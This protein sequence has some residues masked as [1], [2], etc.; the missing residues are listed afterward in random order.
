MEKQTLT[1]HTF[2]LLKA[3]CLSGLFLLSS[4]GLNAQD[5]STSNL[6][7][8][9][10]SQ[11]SYTTCE[12]SSNGVLEAIGFNGSPG[13]SYVWSDGQTTAIAS[14]LDVGDYSV[15]VTDDAGCTAT[16]SGAIS[17]HPEGVWIMTSFTAACSGS[18]SGTA[19]VSAMLGTEPYSYLWSDG[20]TSDDAVGLAS[21][22]YGVTVTDALGCSAE[23]TVTIPNASGLSLFTTSS[24]ETCGGSNDATATVVASG[25]VAPYTYLWD[26]GQTT[27]IATGLS[28]GTIGVTVTDA[29]GCQ[30]T[31]TQ[32]V[33]LSP[34]GIWIM[35]SSTP[36]VCGESNGTAH[37]SVM[38]G[39]PPYTFLWNDPAMQ[40]TAD[41]VGLAAGVY[42]VVVTDSNG[43]E[44]TEMVT[45]DGSNAPNPGSISTNDPVEFC[46]TDGNSHIINVTTTGAD[47][48]AQFAYVLT[49]DALNILNISTTPSFDLTGAPAG[50]CLI[51]RVA[52]DGSL[53]GAS[54]GASATGLGGCFA[55]S[56]P[57]AVTRNPALCC[58]APDPGVISTNDPT[59]FCSTDGNAHI[60]NVDVTGGSSTGNFAFVLTTADLTILEVTASSTFD[61]TGA[62]AGTCLIWRVGYSDISGAEA[63]LNAGNLSG[64]FD[65]SDPIEVVR[66]PSLCCNAP[67]PG[68]IST[69]DPTTFCST[70]GQQ[71]IINVTATGGSSTGN[72][73][74]VLTT[75]DLTILEV[76]PNSSFDI[77]GAPAGTCL[78]WRVG[79]SDISGA[80]VGENAGNLSGCFDL[81]D[82]IEVVRDPSLCCDAPDPGVI[83]TNDPTT[84]CSTDG[85]THIINVNVTGGSSTGNFAYVLTTADLTILEVTT[86]SSFNITGAPAGTC[87]IWRVGYDDIA[88][89]EAGQNAGNLTG[90]FDLSNSIEVVRDPSLCPVDCPTVSIDPDGAQACVGSSVA[91]TA[92]VSGPVLT[93]AWTSSAGSFDDA[94]SATPTYTMMT[95][96]TYTIGVTVTAEGDCTATASSTVTISGSPTVSITPDFASICG[97]GSVDLSATSISGATYSWTASGGS[98]DDATSSTPTYTM[99]MPGTYTIGVTV[100]NAAGCT[101]TASPT[102]V[103]VNSGLASCSAAVT[104]SYNEGTDISVLNGSDG[105]ASASAIGA[106]GALT[107]NWSNG[108][109]TQSID[110]LSAGTYDVVI[111]D[112]VG[113]SCEAS[114]TL[115]DPAK[116]GNYVWEDTNKNGVQDPGESGIEGVK[117]TLTG[118]TVDGLD[119]MRMLFTDATGM[120]MFDGLLPGTYKVTFDTP[121]GYTPTG[122]NLG[123]DDALDSDAGDMGMSQMVTLGPGEYDPT[124]DAGFHTC[125][126]IGNYVW[127]D[128]DQ[129]GRQDD[130][131][132]G[133]ANVKVTLFDRGLDNVACNADDNMI[134]MTTTDENG[135]YLLECVDPGV[136]YVAFSQLPA[137][138]TFTQQDNGGD[139][140]DSD[141]NSDGKTDI[142][143]ITEGQDDDLTI[144]AGIHPICDDAT[145][146]GLVEIEGGDDELCPGDATGLLRSVL[147]AS[148][149]SGPIEYLWMFSDQPVFNTSWT[150]IANSNFE[151]YQ[152]GI[153]SETTYFIRCARRAGCSDY[154]VESNIIKVC[155][156][157]AFCPAANF[158][159]GFGATMINETLVRL[160]WA[161]DAETDVYNYFIYFSTDGENFEELSMLAGNGNAVSNTYQYM[162]NNPEK[163]M[164]Y[165]RL[166]RVGLDGEIVFSEVAEVMV[167]K[168]DDQLSAYPNPVTNSLQIL[169]GQEVTADATVQILSADGKVVGVY[170]VAAGEQTL[171]ADF[172]ALSSGLYFIRINYNDSAKTTETIKIS[173]HK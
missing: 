62:P 64:C 48:N 23:T 2:L 63:G 111:T 116:L 33:E 76:T 114:V 88:G 68:V 141:V 56:D 139:A 60:I 159:M 146:G 15:I 83:S 151:D 30:A 45:I 160:D 91:L 106:T 96:G 90:C 101:G 8:I 29:N 94:S 110:G 57:I 104:S 112:E 71:H 27:D 73:A 82:P 148:G 164:N 47:A 163:G 78:I 37:V 119:I 122:S 124:I 152:P 125:I 44:A 132:E 10:V 50:I 157:D 97:G 74:Y 51:W 100:T 72:F 127:Y 158:A 46:S 55:L 143:I 98:F 135:F 17:L 168:G 3:F 12:V 145:D 80:V 4:F 149:G 138:W 118:T 70:D 128:L 144:D 7:V 140:I 20:Q 115:E 89:A 130:D 41:P 58:D 156:D 5:C 32:T 133:V 65:L 167:T 35:L 52:H 16:A 24:Y 136:Y 34:E 42:T 154:I 53:T 81:S 40:T 69:N 87:L 102:T 54:V 36:S 1:Q 142:I 155:V 79:Y 9:V 77:T 126:N 165:Y 95:P 99:M 170:Q 123:G 134:M 18:A 38:T 61:I 26:G 113:C 105:S 43:C 19:H 13:Y 39:V 120:Y 171:D 31:A 28:A 169:I 121:T 117:V 75:S 137:D 93:Y 162:H 25:G 11:P 85:N 173:K 84:F 172:S 67:D 131:E 92:N 166:K 108:A 103:T 21:G 14:G 22:P 161:T 150:P 49:D 109:S 6:G 153:L 59:T 129:D 107:Y 147:P 66:D 86:N